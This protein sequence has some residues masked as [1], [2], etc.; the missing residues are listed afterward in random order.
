MAATDIALA[1]HPHNSQPAFETKPSSATMP[2]FHAYAI[3]QDLEVTVCSEL[4]TRVV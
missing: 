2:P 1:S 3:E 4:L